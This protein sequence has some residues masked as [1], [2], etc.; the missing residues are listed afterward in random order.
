MDSSWV[1][2]DTRLDLNLNPLPHRFEVP[3]R[4]FQGDFAGFEEKV[5]VKVKPREISVLEDELNRISTENKRL[6]EMLT[7]ICE[8]YSIL[9]KQYMD[10]ISKNSSSETEL[11]ASKKRKPDSEDYSKMIGF[12]GHTECSSSDEESCKKPKE[13]TK[14][15]VSRIYMRTSAADTASLIMKDG[16]QWRKYGQKVTRDNP[17]PRAYFKCSFAPSCPVKK[18]VQ[19][20]AEDP[21]VLVATYEG[22]HNHPPPKKPELSLSPSQGS[23]V[24]PIS[25]ARRSQGPAVTL[26]MF[27]GGVSDDAKKS[28]QEVEAPAIRQ[29]LVQQMAASLTKDPTFTAALAAAIS[30]R[31]VDQGRT[32][33]W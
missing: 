21:S 16:Y 28:V 8:N 18:K 13:N 30:G 22:E 10:L 26:D 17:S 7:V 24:G 33:K 32:E 4:E 3:K 11:T 27:Q 9:E 20:S 25:P 31:F 6:S 15:K 1:D 2:L 19:R 23:T 5:S 29:I 14:T 12:N